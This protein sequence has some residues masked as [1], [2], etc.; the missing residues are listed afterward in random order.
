MRRRARCGRGCPR[1]AREHAPAARC[2]EGN[3]RPTSSTQVAG[4]GLSCTPACAHVYMS[5]SMFT[6]CPVYSMSAEVEERARCSGAG[7]GRGADG[8]WI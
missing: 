1:P 2:P 3:E 7:E 8:I 4:P 6:P 5:M